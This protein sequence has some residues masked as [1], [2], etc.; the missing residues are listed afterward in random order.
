MIVQ[1]KAMFGFAVRVRALP[2]KQ[3]WEGRVEKPVQ[4]GGRDASRFSFPRTKG[5]AKARMR[6]GTATSGPSLQIMLIAIGKRVDRCRTGRGSGVPLVCY[7]LVR[8]NASAAPLL[9]GHALSPRQS[10]SQICETPYLPLLARSLRP[11]IWNPRPAISLSANASRMRIQVPVKVHARR[12]TMRAAARPICAY[13]TLT[14]CS[15]SA[16]LANCRR[17]QSNHTRNA[18]RYGS[19]NEFAH[20]YGAGSL[21]NRGARCGRPTP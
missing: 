18:W 10:R 4:C 5:E 6:S 14:G 8:E 19:R 13:M 17:C 15:R 16:L 3:N 1:H 9:R 7:Q 11:Q 12:R 20:N 2:E 21:Q